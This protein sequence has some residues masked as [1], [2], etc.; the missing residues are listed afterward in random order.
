MQSLPF[1]LT[2]LAIKAL[3][4]NQH[5]RVRAGA[6]PRLAAVATEHVG[7]A[8]AS[9]GLYEAD[10]IDLVRKVLVASNLQDTVML[11][12]GANIG[13]HTCALASHVGRVLAFEPNPPTAA[14]LRANALL[15]DLP[16]VTV[17]EVGL[18]EVDAELPY[19]IVEE[20]ND[21]SGA[22]GVSPSG[23]TL[24]VRNGDAFLARHE[25]R[26]ADGNQ[27]IGFIKCDVQGFERDVFAGLSN[28]LRVHQPIIMFE[29]DNHADGMASW[30]VL[31][32]CGYHNLARIRAP[33][34]D[35]GKLAREW[36]RLRQGTACWLEPIDA[37][38]PAHCNLLASARSLPTEL[39]RHG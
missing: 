15:N 38:P 34:D 16:Q 35:L 33:G 10:E 36:Q 17:H 28:T 31:Q 2:D 37:L 30:K 11:D 14:L 26:I 3:I 29:S 9:T 19:G 1:R 18:A 21:G 12:I 6:P 13:N 24:P 20:G 25:R 23:K 39:F 27:R 5:A 7:I 32:A 22:F 8:I 4:K